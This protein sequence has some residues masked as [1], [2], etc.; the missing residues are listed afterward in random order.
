M[1]KKICGGVSSSLTYPCAALK[2]TDEPEEEVHVE[3]EEEIEE[4]EGMLSRRPVADHAVPSGS[5]SSSSSRRVRRRRRRRMVAAG[6]AVVREEGGVESDGRQW[7]Q[8]GQQSIAAVAMYATDDADAHRRCRLLLLS[9]SLLLTP[10]VPVPVPV[11]LTF[12]PASPPSPSP[13]ASSFCLLSSSFCFL[14]LHGWMDGW[15][16]RDDDGHW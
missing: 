10:P 8:G 16:S 2:E 6:A 1:Q 14:R 7:K 9:L 5:S 13:L 11:P 12:A 4:C 15:M 3:E